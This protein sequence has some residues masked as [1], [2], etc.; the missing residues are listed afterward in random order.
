[1]HTF[2]ILNEAVD[3]DAG[4]LLEKIT[5]AASYRRASKIDLFVREAIRKQSPFLHWLFC[6]AQYK[7]WTWLAR[8]VFKVC[9]FNLTERRSYNL[10]TIYEARIFGRVVSRA[11]I[12]EI[13]LIKI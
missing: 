10:E 8:T 4:D 3:C 12:K 2:S 7:K 13:D 1:M 6:K 9:R 5:A 11:I